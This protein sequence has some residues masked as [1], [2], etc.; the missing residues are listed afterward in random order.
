MTQKITIDPITRLEG[1]G[2]IE[3]F[4]DDAGDVRRAYFQVPELRGF[5]QFAVGR[6]AED[7][8]QITSRICG[9][10]PTAHHLAS[11]KALDALYRVEPP[12]AA[13][14]IRE[15][16]NSTFFVEDH[17]LHFYF[18]GGP[19]FVVGPS[20]PASERNVLGVIAKVGLETGQK[21]IAM[22]R[23]LR[24]LMALAAGKPI[25]PVFGLPGGVAKALT[26]DDQARCRTIAGEAVDFA[27]FTL[28]LFDQVVLKNSDY[29]QLITSDAFTHRTYYMGLVDD[30]NRVNFYEGTVRVV[31]PAGQEHARFAAA[32]YLDHVAEHTEPW[33]YMKF[34]YLKEVGWK[35]F[36]DGPQ[37]GVYAV[38]PL[39]RLN[40]AEGLAT[41]AASEACQQ[42]YATLGGR[43]VHQTLATHWA[44]VIE[45]LYAAERLKELAEDPGLTD[46]HVRNLPRETPRE[47]VGVIEAPR[48]TLFHHYETDEHGIIR[49]AN[50]IVATQNNAARIAMSVDK[51]AKALIAKGVVNDGLLNMVEMA[52]RAY[53]PCH[54][55]ATH[56][57]PGSMPLLIRVHDAR[58]NVV[59]QLRRKSSDER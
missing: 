48:G 13:K 57:L 40:V 43:P 20:A 11:T 6:P 28:D 18:L 52:F 39:A 42:F 32:N 35:G 47:G 22:R 54:G 44:R 51:A 30:Q 56:A 38:A 3:I 49:K 15:L 16:V 53:D 14:K 5:E 9:V 41:P 12:P 31:D 26:A 33:S 10:C 19:D 24:E 1:H 17:A 23:K 21:V 4:L 7:M 37:S 58:G 2:K 46:P 27:K 25:H 45:L 50:L 29:V 8:P 36:T 59:A 34:C 55:C